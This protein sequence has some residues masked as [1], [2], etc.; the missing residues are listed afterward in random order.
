MSIIK[1]CN[2]Y[3]V[4]PYEII[5]YD[6]RNSDGSLPKIVIGKY[7][8]IAKNCTFVLANHVMDRVTTA[9]APRSIYSHRQGNTSGF[10]RGNIIIGNDVWI[11]TRCMI[12]DGVTIGDGAICAAGSVVTKNVPPYA[13]VGGNPARIIKYRFSEDIIARLLAVNIWGRSSEELSRMD[14]WTSDIDGFLKK[15]ESS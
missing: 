11:G 8:S 4:D 13:I 1:G 3:I 14:L 7:C 2:S 5:N 9:P 15:Y 6:C 12:M 10:S